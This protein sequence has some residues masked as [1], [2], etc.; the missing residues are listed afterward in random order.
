MSDLDKEL[1]AN[2]IVQGVEDCIC[3][4]DYEGHIDLLWSKTREILI[5][6]NHSRT[7]EYWSCIGQE[8]EDCWNITSK[9]RGLPCTENIG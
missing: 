6:D 8:L 4:S 5:N 3:Y 2:I 9:M 1:L 7:V